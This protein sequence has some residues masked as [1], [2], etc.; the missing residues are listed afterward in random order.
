MRNFYI[1]LNE[2]S[3]KKPRIIRLLIF[4]SLVYLSSTIASLSIFMKFNSSL[5]W[6]IIVAVIYFALYIY[7]AWLTFTTNRFV[8]ANDNGIV[9]KFGIR[10]SMANVIIWDSINKVRI[11]YAYI[12]FYKKSG[13]IKKV[14]LSW[15]P[16]IKIIE[17]KEKLEAFCKNKDIAYDKIDFI[18]Y[19]KRKDKKGQ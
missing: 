4:G 15:L 11:G 9:F 19:S 5:R 17:I 1:D 10:S 2:Y 7:F 18:K 14:H 13:R 6:L 12:A 3:S 8:K 16:Y